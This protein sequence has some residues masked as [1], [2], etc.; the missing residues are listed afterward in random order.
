MSSCTLRTVGS[1][2]ASEEDC[3]AAVTNSLCSAGTCECDPK[4]KVSVEPGSSSARDRFLGA[5]WIFPPLWHPN[6]FPFFKCK[7]RKLKLFSEFDNL[8][9]A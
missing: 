1:P 7:V 5:L 6:S 9:T 4:F 8:T 3:A 2:C